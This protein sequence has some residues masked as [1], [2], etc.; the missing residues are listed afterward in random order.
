MDCLFCKI[1]AGQIPSKK[2]YEDDK[3]LAF[4]DIAPQAPV[5]ILVIPKSHISSVDDI[6]A[7]NSDIIAYIFEKIPS[8]AKAAGIKN[9]YR[10][11]S[12]CGSDACQSVKHLHFH[13]LGGAQLSDKMA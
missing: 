9:G 6:T 13:I 7:E 10:V 1:V 8:I 12:N 3:L 5:H 11:I 4:Y 2:A